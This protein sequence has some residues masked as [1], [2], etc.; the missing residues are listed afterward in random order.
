[1]TNKP[2]KRIQIDASPQLVSQLEELGQLIDAAT[3]AETVRRAVSL[4]L[5]LAREHKDKDGKLEIIDKE[6]KSRILVLF[7]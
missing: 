6:G 7:F 2:R 3:A 4:A 1:M 5:G